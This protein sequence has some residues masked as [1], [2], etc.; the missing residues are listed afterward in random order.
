MLNALRQWGDAEISPESFETIGRVMKAR[1]GFTLEGYKDKCVKRRISLRV[2]RTQSASAEEYTALLI[3][4]PVEQEQLLR[5]LTINVSQFF[6][7]PS[8]FHKISSQILPELMQR[9]ASGGLSVVS[10]GCAAGEEP[11]SLALILRERYGRALA[12][13]PV[14]IR[15]TDVDAACLETA[16]EALYHPDRLAEVPAE[17]RSRWFTSETGQFRLSPEIRSLVSFD[18][19]DL[20]QPLQFGECDLILCRNVLIYFERVRQEA[21]LNGFADSLRSGGYLVLGKSETLFGSARRRFR[22]VCPVER[23]YKVIS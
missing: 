20:N 10:V 1:F 17:L 23:I 19:G 15:G 12:S 11:Y 16:K 18:H 22:T 21:I 7:N 3:D 5:V 8:T 9:S 4:S 6:R 14:T 2:R 13:H